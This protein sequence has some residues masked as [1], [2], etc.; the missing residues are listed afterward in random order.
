[1]DL[2]QIFLEIGCLHILQRDN[3]REF[4]AAVIQE[5]TSLWSTYKIVNGRPGHP[6]SQGSVERSNQDVE[7]MLRAWLN[8]ND[9]KIT[10]CIVK[11]VTKEDLDL[12]LN[13]QDHDT[14]LTTEHLPAASLEN[15][16]HDSTSK[17]LPA[18]ELIDY[19]TSISKDLSIVKSP[20]NNTSMSH[21]LSAADILPKKIFKFR[22]I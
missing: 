18:S 11:H 3:G 13:Q 8:D 6:A 20:N 14:I 4:T 12:L 10:C 1:M 16:N 5:L 7:A 2:S 9:T 22:G 21:N 15:N 17:D 19:N